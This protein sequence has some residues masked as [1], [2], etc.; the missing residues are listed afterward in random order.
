MSIESIPT[1]LSWVLSVT[2]FGSIGG[3]ITLIWKMSAYETNRKRDIS[4]IK[5]RVTNI[6]AVVS[7]DG[8]VKQI[9]DLQLN[10]RGKMTEVE[11]KIISHVSLPGHG[12]LPQEVSALD[13]R[14]TN[15]EKHNE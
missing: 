1:G 7:K 8:V 5:D 3:I 9:Q 15:L 13:A 4:E 6:E 10:C 12:N 14:V 2:G 11:N